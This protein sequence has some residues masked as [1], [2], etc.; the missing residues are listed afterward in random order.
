MSTISKQHKSKIQDLIYSDDFQSTSQG[1]ELLESLIEDEQGIYDIFDVTGIVP[2][3]M[4]ELK[5]KIFDCE[6]RNSISVWIL[7]KLAEYGVDWVVRLTS[8]DLNGS[9]LTFLPE[10]IGHFTNLTSLDLRGN[11][12]S[13]LPESLENLTNLTRLDLSSNQLS[14]LSEEQLESLFVSICKIQNLNELLLGHNQLTFLPE[15][16]GNLTRLT[17]FGL[18]YNQL[19]SVPSSIG[20]LTNLTTLKLWGAHLTTLPDSIGNL[21]NLTWLEMRRNHRL[22]TLP[23]TIVNLVSL[24]EN[25]LCLG[26]SY[27]HNLSNE[28]CS[29]LTKLM[30]G[31]IYWG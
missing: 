3:N 11:Q 4:Q 12:L 22:V 13:S 25:T 29:R 14:N 21:R 1:L 7:L 18:S 16:I 23:D 17:K 15:S 9:K 2:S 6:H 8:L 31:V 19:T 26:N 24:R 27:N 20:N 30:G 10:S 28:E 5:E